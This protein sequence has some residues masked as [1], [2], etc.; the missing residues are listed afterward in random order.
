MLACLS[1]LLESQGN[2]FQCFAYRAFIKF[3]D[4]APKRLKSALESAIALL[5]KLT[6]LWRS[7]ELTYISYFR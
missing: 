1:D 2:E 4:P 3:G 5:P 7:R 6:K